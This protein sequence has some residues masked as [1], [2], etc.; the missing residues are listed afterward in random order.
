M[1]AS[2]Q[3]SGHLEGGWVVGLGWV[4]GRNAAT[5]WAWGISSWT[6]TMNNPWQRAQD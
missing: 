1:V 2:L 4:D 6:F 5:A 3:N